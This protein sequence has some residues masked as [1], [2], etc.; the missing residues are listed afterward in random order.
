MPTGGTTPLLILR[1]LILHFNPRAHGGHDLIVA[2]LR[3][4]RGIS[5]HVPTGGTT[6]P[7][8]VRRSLQEFQSTCPRGAR[9]R[10]R[11]WGSF[12][13]D[14]NP[15]AHGGHDA[16]YTYQVK[17]EECIFQS[18]C[19]RGARLPPS[20]GRKIPT[21]ISIHVPTG[22]TTFGWVRCIWIWAR[23]SIHVPTGGTTL[24]GVRRLAEAGISIHVPTGGTTLCRRRICISPN[25]NPRAHG[26]HDFLRG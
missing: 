8:R 16:P 21:K 9:P 22:G 19:P 20:H 10:T 15:R 17:R 24:G 26:G 4:L 7:L 18:T 25:F 11:Q 23:I 1:K 6:Q 3:H 13:L 14:F 2:V 12:L 5:I